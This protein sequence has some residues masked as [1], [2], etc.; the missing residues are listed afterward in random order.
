[1]GIYFDKCHKC[2]N[3]A[4]YND[5]YDSDCCVVCNI[6]LTKLCDCEGCFH[7]ESRPNVPNIP[8][9]TDNNELQHIE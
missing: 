2:G 4:L 6:W 5:R 8:I 3:E 9:V 1:M 7:C